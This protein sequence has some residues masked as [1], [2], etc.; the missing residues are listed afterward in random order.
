MTYNKSEIGR[1]TS[2]L[3]FSFPV[4]R[5]NVMLRKIRLPRVK[6]Y[7]SMYS[8]NQFIFNHKLQSRSRPGLCDDAADTENTAQTLGKLVKVPPHL[9]TAFFDHFSYQV[10]FLFQINYR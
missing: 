1:L 4:N 9:N 2:F 7:L 5:L 3:K 10:S 6:N 8:I